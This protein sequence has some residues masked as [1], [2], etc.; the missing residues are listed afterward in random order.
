LKGIA[1][2]PT[3]EA[4]KKK[5]FYKSTYLAQELRNQ[6]ENCMFNSPIKDYKTLSNEI[7]RV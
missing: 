7:L 4:A 1:C 2:L 3:Y 6:Q 5:Y